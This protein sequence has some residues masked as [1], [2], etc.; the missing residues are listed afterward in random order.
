MKKI[1][2]C[3][4][5]DQNALEAAELYVS[6]FESSSIGLVTHYLEDDASPSELPAGTPLTVSFTLC[7]QV[8]TGLNG[9]PVFQPTPALSFYV[10][11][12]NEAQF[13]AL[14]VKLAL[15]GTVM[16]EV[17]EYPFSKKFGWLADRF[18][19]S[20]Q[21][22]LT[23]EKQK[24]T[25]YLMFTEG[26]HG[27]AEE[28]I[29]YYT[30]LF[31]DAKPLH[32]QRYGKDSGSPEGTVM[33]ATFQLEGQAFMAADSAHPHGFTFNEA[34]SLCVYCRNQAEIDRLWNALTDGGEEQPCGWAKDR[35]G[36]SWQIV[37]HNMDELCDSA[38]PIRAGRVNHAM[39][40]MKKLDMQALRDA[41]D[42][43]SL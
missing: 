20:W 17:A 41:F 8:F 27:K 34:V 39:M 30:G 32:I 38:D 11:C 42:G 43:R 31:N 22:S 16:M 4:W 14:W 10:D 35:F 40:E 12:E 24:I 36:V 26:V 7:G 33:F 13:D 37:P 25:P 6:A 18:G 1:T 21:L 3:I 19:V 5:Y 15:G 29:A 9:G 23:G 2:P 28:A